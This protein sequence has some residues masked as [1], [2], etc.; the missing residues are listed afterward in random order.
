MCGLASVLRSA[1]QIE[2][3]SPILGPTYPRWRQYPRKDPVQCDT[4]TGT[5]VAITSP[6]P[7]EHGREERDDGLKIQV[8]ASTSRGLTEDRRGRQYQVKSLATGTY[9]PGSKT[10]ATGT[11]AEA[12]TMW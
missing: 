8:K 3:T 11:R 7:F 6:P 9:Q 5:G 4:R 1:M 10:K 2:V 12:W